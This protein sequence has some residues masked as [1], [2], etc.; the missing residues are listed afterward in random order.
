[1]E[2]EIEEDE[3]LP[4]RRR[5][6]RRDGAQRLLRGEVDR[7]DRIDDDLFPLVIELEVRGGE[8]ADRVAARVD[9]R[10]RHFDDVD[11]DR[12]LNLRGRRDGE[13]GQH[14]EKA[15]SHDL[16]RASGTNEAYA[17]AIPRAVRR[18]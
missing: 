1:G 3:E 13:R 9:D 6:Q 8:A 16:V 5:I 15:I 17:P 12:L 4:P 10:Y 7:V 18:L 14:Y 11:G 2:R